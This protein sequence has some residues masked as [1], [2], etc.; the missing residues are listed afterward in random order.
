MYSNRDAAEKK[1]YAE[2]KL[3]LL[4]FD[5]SVRGLSPGAPVEFRGIQIGEVIDLKL[6]YD[7]NKKI[8]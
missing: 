2:K 1:D 4:N 5:T 3:F 8:L 6:E 7:A